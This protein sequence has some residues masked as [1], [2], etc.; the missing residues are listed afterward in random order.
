MNVEIDMIFHPA[1]RNYIAEDFQ[2]TI[3]S[4]RPLF[5]DD[6]FKKIDLIILTD[7]IAN[8]SKQYGGHSKEAT[9]GCQLKYNN[10]IIIII[11]YNQCNCSSIGD[12]SLSVQAAHFLCHEVTH[13]ENL[14]FENSIK[15][16]IE[17]SSHDNFIID[18]S[19]FLYNEFLAEF[20]AQSLIPLQWHS[21]IYASESF[22]HYVDSSLSSIYDTMHVL[23]NR[24]YSVYKNDCQIAIKEIVIFMNKMRYR[25]TLIAAQSIAD[26]KK[27]V[28]DLSIQNSKIQQLVQDFINAL[29]NIDFANKDWGN[30]LLVCIIRFV[31]HTVISCRDD[32]Y[33]ASNSLIRC[34]F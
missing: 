7:N 15:T 5:A 16:Q 27:F 13:V 18:E 28:I 34:V 9:G 2:K 23:N 19:W 21:N 11:N 3:N 8:K 30:Q 31:S 24:P 29:N 4:I 6:I 1:I 20:K 12:C 25:L 14:S 26:N 33:T 10:Q 17:N 32:F 22:C